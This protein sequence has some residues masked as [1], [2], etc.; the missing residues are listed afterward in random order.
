MKFKVPDVLQPDPLSEVWRISC[1]DICRLIFRQYFILE[2]IGYQEIVDE[3]YDY[4][5]YN[6][7][8][9]VKDTSGAD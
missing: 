2:L 4:F 9:R 8:I 1:P 7:A 6:R 3:L 5:K